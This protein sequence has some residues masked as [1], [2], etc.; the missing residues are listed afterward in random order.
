MTRPSHAST[1]PVSLTERS[2]GVTR[3]ETARNRSRESA[4]VAA[5]VRHGDGVAAPEHRNASAYSSKI[6]QR[7]IS[8]DFIIFWCTF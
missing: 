4:L 6:V 2:S 8:D 1:G 3:P 7:I 5:A